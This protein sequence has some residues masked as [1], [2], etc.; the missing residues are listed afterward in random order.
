MSDKLQITGDMTPKRYRCECGYESVHSTNHYGSFYD[1]CP[2]CSWKSPM[3]PI[4]V[5]ACLE[6]LPDG[7]GR[8]EP[9][10]MVELKDIATIIKGAK[11]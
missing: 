7:W 6:P 4:K 10:K 9:W 2:K 5:H 3:S 8:P 1:H 11:R